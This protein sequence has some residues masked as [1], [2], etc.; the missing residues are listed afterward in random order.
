MDTL[1]RSITY[2]GARVATCTEFPVN[3]LAGMRRVEDVM[4][5][6]I[7]LHIT[8]PLPVPALDE[9]ADRVFAWFHEVDR[10]FSTYKPDSEGNRVQRGELDAASGSPDL[11]DVLDGCARLWRATARDFDLYAPRRLDPPRDVTG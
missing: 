11:R 9:L 2:P 10:R 8:D 7:S 3:D 4:G 6:A 5:T 1:R